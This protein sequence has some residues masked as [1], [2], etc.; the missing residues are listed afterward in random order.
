M[1][2]TPQQLK[3]AASQRPIRSDEECRDLEA[4]DLLAWAILDTT[5]DVSMKI[6]VHGMNGEGRELL[7]RL[8]AYDIEQK[9]KRL[10]AVAAAVL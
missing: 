1:P 10:A 7:R 5:H 6:V 9:A 8:R 3:D 2:F 4:D